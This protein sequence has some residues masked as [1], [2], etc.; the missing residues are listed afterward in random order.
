M[1]IM[2]ICWMWSIVKLPEKTIR[3]VAKV[4]VGPRIRANSKTKA[5]SMICGGFILL[6]GLSGLF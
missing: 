3:I 6:T 5:K 1:Y 4:R 2:I